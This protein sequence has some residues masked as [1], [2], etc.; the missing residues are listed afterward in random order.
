[1]VTRQMRKLLRAAYELAVIW[2]LG[3]LI[4]CLLF[5]GATGGLREWWGI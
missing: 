5:I 3:A 2:L 4:G 1:M